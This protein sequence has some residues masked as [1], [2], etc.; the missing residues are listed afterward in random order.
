MR[1]LLKALERRVIASSPIV[2]QGAPRPQP[3]VWRHF[4][5]TSGAR[6][7][8]RNSGGVAGSRRR[9]R[10]DGGPTAASKSWRSER[11]KTAEVARSSP[12]PRH[13]SLQKLE[14]NG[15]SLFDDVEKILEKNQ[16]ERKKTKH[17]QR[18]QH[19]TD[20][21]PTRNRTNPER[22]E[23]AFQERG[24]M[25]IFK[26]RS[27]RTVTGASDSS[28][29]PTDSEKRRDSDA[30]IVNKESFPSYASSF[31][32]RRGLSLSPDDRGLFDVFR[33]PEEDEQ[34]APA[35]SKGD[36]EIDAHAWQ[37]YRE[38][39]EDMVTN[40]VRYQKKHT[41]KPISDAVATPVTSWLSSS[42]DLMPSAQPNDNLPSLR[43]ALGTDVEQHVLSGY[44]GNDRSNLRSAF[45]SE[46]EERR[47][48]FKERMGWDQNQ[49]RMAQGALYHIANQCARQAKGSTLPIVWEK[50]KEA[51]FIDQKLL[52]TLLYV[53]ATFCTGNRRKNARYARLAGNGGTAS[54]ILDML[55]AVDNTTT[56]V[57]FSS[58]INCSSNDSEAENLVDRTDEIAVC[59]DRKMIFG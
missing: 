51:G 5:D 21:D 37:Q 11:Q 18:K 23:K 41:A 4:A 53:S 16:Q 14:S 52:Q 34:E 25:P 55:E 56:A 6:G 15:A 36:D 45:R 30:G 42:E 26:T 12:R 46:V 49:Y 32:D 57:A 50:V 43:R 20:S 33:I 2:V 38:L 7:R 9:R 28:T 10:G 59:H 1:S 3:I 17:Q 44:S 29:K 48:R 35:F 22:H 58:P 40:D 24:E 47:K 39:L 8:T 27:S 54:T 31:F 13:G 19:R